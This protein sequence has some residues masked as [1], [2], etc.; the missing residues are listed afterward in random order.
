MNRKF[1]AISIKIENQFLEHTEIFE[2]LTDGAII[3]K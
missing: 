2:N 1:L 3:F